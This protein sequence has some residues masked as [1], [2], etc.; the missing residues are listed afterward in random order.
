MIDGE[1]LYIG[2][3]N[4]DPRSANLNTEVGVLLQSAELA[5]SVENSI[6]RDMQ[7][8]NSWNAASG[9]DHHAPFTKRLEMQFWRYYRLNRSCKAIK[10]KS[11]EILPGLLPSFKDRQE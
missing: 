9:P 3:F 8:E 10:I 1:A 4:L 7:P 11:F 2:T 5:W 6:F